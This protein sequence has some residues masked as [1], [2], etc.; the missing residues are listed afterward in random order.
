MSEGSIIG[1]AEEIHN[2]LLSEAE[3]QL[4]EAERELEELEEGFRRVK[5]VEF[6]A[7]GQANDILLPNEKHL[8]KGF[9]KSREDAKR[10]KQFWQTRLMALRKYDVQSFEKSY[11]YDTR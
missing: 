3:Q 9:F 10:K 5:M 8:L 1:S 4:E 7:R 11:K 2:D 6:A